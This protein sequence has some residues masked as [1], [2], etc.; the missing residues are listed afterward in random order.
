[1]QLA[2]MST[3][4]RVLSIPGAAA[5]SGS[6]ALA[7]LPMAMVGLGTVLMLSGL[8]R[9]YTL[10]GLV[11]GTVSL[12]QGAASP[13]VS[14]LI[15]RLGQHRV[16]LP[17]LTSYAISLGVL[18]AAAEHDTPGWALVAVAVVVGVS[19]PQFGACARARW[20]ALLAGDPDM[21]S[22]L[23]IESLIDEALFILG[24]VLVAALAT[25][26]APEAGLLVALTVTVLGGLL[27]VAQRRTEPVPVPPGPGD[28]PRSA[29]RSAG[30]LLVIGVFF[31]IGVLFGLTE[32][33]VVALT[34]EQ[35]HA[36]AAGIMLGLWATGSLFCGIAY[37]A[38]AWRLPA[39]RRFQLGSAAMTV[40]AVLIALAA[41]SLTLVTVALIVAG[42]ANG[43]TLITG[44]T[45]VPLVVPPAAVTEAYTWLSVTIFAGIAVGSPLGGILIDHHGAQASLWASSVAGAAAVAVTTLGRRYLSRDRAASRPG[46][47]VA[48]PDRAVR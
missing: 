18:V 41:P 39:S 24:P 40:G 17:Q 32:V 8:G 16:L 43:P 30:L 9:S 4:R 2:G 1:M 44:N 12:S 48:S 34:R 31:G 42:L 27:F 5:F 3:Y 47:A 35:H 23:A 29:I 33:G 19:F 13:F 45:L 36:G 28:R 15:D 26:I 21:D 46:E 14:R 10:A 11:A 37:G 7:R 20:T 22:A 25:S 38:V 6:G